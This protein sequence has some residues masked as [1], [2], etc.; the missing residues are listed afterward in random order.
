MREIKNLPK[1]GVESVCLKIIARLDAGCV[2]TQ[3]E[4]SFLM[5]AHKTQSQEERSMAKERDEFKEFN[6]DE[7]RALMK[8][9]GTN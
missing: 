4:A 9:A 5:A 1:A 7:L 2:L 6:K 8:H 3:A